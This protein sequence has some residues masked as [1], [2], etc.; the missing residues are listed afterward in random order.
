[1]SMMIPAEPV[2]RILAAQIGDMSLDNASKEV[3]IKI[4][5]AKVAEL[6]DELDSLRPRV[7]E[8]SNSG[9]SDKAKGGSK[10]VRSGG[11]KSSPKKGA[12][13]RKGSK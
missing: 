3:H 9:E 8:E 6:E 11:S 2:A 5:E 7:R 10:K 12:G 13:R 1:M 4:L